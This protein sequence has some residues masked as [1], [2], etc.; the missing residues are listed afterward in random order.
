MRN[1]STILTI[2]FFLS[3][4][5]FVHAQLMDGS[6]GTFTHADSLRGGLRVER[7]CYDVTFYN[8]NITLDIPNKSISGYNQI[9]FNTRKDFITMQ[10]DLF[11]N[12]VID[13]ILYKGTTL[14][15]TR[16]ANAVFVQMTDTIRKFN[17]D[18]I[19]V[20][21][22]GNPI[23]AK[24]APWDG[25]FVFTKDNEDK[26]WVGVA[27][28]GTGASLWWPCKDHLS[29]EPDSMEVTCNYPKDLFF[30]GNG[31]MV[32]NTTS[33]TTNLRT[34]SW[35]SSYPIN[36]YNVTL[37]IGN[38]KHFSDI[39]TSKKLGKNLALDYYV[40]PYNYDKAVKQFK[41][42]KPMMAIYEKYL[43]PYP[44]W[45]DGYALVETPYLGMEHQGAI[46]YGNNYK[47]G[48]AGSDYS[49][50]GLDFDYIIIHETG[51]EWWGNSIS[52]KDIA[53]M[54]IHESFCTY[55]EA[56]YVEGM[57]GKKKAQEYINA[58]K[59]TID[60]KAPIQ[61]KY[62]VNNEGD[63]DMY[64]KGMLFLNTLRTVVN[65]DSLWFAT[66]Y[67]MLN[68]D[69]YHKNADY[70]DV[71]RYF[72]Q[73]TRKFVNPLFEQYI[74]KTNI[75]LLVYKI[76]DKNK[77]MKTIYYKW[78]VDV[79]NFQMRFYFQYNG[80]KDDAIATNEWRSYDIRVKNIKKFVVDQ[81]RMYID[82]QELK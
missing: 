39:Y 52:C 67:K 23:V 49:R 1:S 50:I 54:W 2:L 64:N 12:M 41:Q 8:L 44:F 70:N 25:G 28:E 19:E 33:T 15:Y 72:E 51:H 63:G 48:Y 38:Y 65:N 80:K 47:T 68:T 59:E 37:N 21:Y 35:K 11:E 29:D 27:C 61:G 16:D 10:I 14:K 66:L 75:P 36:N 57:Y 9:Y 31:Q 34:T 74:Q 22:H 20:H 46:A 55:S 82:V 45:N 71:V 79:L 13:K 81:N 73:T 26:D 7:T 43:G 40:M 53:D 30:V 77:F 58:K 32:R 60:N 17:S 69:Y 24:R 42:V 62:G 4:L 76:E 6:N 18:M 3:S 78:K 5:N 56:L